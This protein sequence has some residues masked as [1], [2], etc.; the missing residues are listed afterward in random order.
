MGYKEITGRMISQIKKRAKVSSIKYS[1]TKEYLY[2]LFISQDKKCA[3]SK[4]PIVLGVTKDDET[5]ASLDRINSKLGYIEGNVQWLHKH[6]NKM[7]LDHSQ[8]YFITLCENVARS[9]YNSFK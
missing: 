4:M 2:K 6:I 7:K 3:L 1:L 5:T 8:E 9:N